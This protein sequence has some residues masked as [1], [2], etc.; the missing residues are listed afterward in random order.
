MSLMKTSDAESVT[1]TH[2]DDGATSGLSL[3]VSAGMLAALLDGELIGNPDVPLSTLGSIESGSAEAL[4]FI[5]S[6]NF[7]KFWADSECGC[8][9]VSEGIEVPGH[10]PES[11]AIIIVQD[12][13]EAMVMVLDAVNPKRVRPEIGIH[14]SAVI[15]PDAVIDPSAAIG[16]G[17]V[18][19]AR[20]SIGANVVLM[21]NV[22]IG[23]NTRIGEDTI[24]EPGVVVEDRCVVG[25]RCHLGA[26][27]VIGTDGFGYLPA[28]DSRPAMKVPQIGTVEIGND[29]E[30]G[31]CVTVDRAKFGATTIGD[32]AKI[33]NQVH[34]AHNCVVGT[35]TLIA[36]RTTLGGSVVVG[37]FA[38]IGGAAVLND[39][40]VVGKNAKVAGGAVVLESVPD[41]E[42]YVG[43]PA[44]PAR[45][46]LLN[47]SA[48]RDLGS[49]VRKV[50]KRLKK[51]ESD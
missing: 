44:M 33:D 51:L 24:L 10:D 14:S 48:F 7:A 6:S 37:D 21:C 11:K 18:V 22:T 13:D 49:F 38:M 32:R 41:G 28:N 43:T 17:C 19:G 36:G 5:R 29:V 12:A 31:A 9:L 2:G 23:V 3:P 39:Q 20:S 34:V 35:D 46:A 15:D 4:T 16:P 50:E 42:T 25:S 27:C 45:Q 47:Y 40:S 8:A 1:N 30:L 26:N